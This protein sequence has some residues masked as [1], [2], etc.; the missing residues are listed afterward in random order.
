M[1][2]GTSTTPVSSLNST[3]ATSTPLSVT[4]IVPLVIGSPVTG[5]VNV[6]ITLVLPA[7][8]LPGTAVTL[9]LRCVTVTVSGFVAGTSS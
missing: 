3:R 5:S 1:F 4:T 8:V 9:L 2:V 7:T 6:T